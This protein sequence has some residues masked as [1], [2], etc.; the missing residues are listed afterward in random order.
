MCKEKF[1]C[2]VINFDG[3]SDTVYYDGKIS[4]LQTINKWLVKTTTIRK[5]I[6]NGK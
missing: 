3:K 1:H 4:D 2:I 5:D 6:G